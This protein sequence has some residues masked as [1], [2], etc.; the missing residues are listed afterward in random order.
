MDSAVNAPMVK[1]TNPNCHCPNIGCEIHGKCAECKRE[2]HNKNMYC[3]LSPW[4][5]KINDWMCKVL[6]K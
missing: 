4:R 2:H 3:T 1:K 5:K 6:P